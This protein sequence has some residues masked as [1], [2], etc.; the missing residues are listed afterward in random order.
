MQSRVCC[1]HCSG[2]PR[3]M[4][5]ARCAGHN[6]HS[7]SWSTRSFSDGSVLLNKCSIMCTALPAPAS[8]MVSPTV[9]RT[10][11]GHA[12]HHTMQARTSLRGPFDVPH[13]ATR[14]CA[15]QAQASV[16]GGVRTTDFLLS[17]PAGRGVTVRAAVEV[18]GPHHF[19]LSSATGKLE[20][21]NGSTA[22][23]D[24]ALRR[25]G[26]SVVTVPLAGRRAVRPGDDDFDTALA[27]R[28]WAVGVPLLGG[29]AAPARAPGATAQQ[30]ATAQYAT[31]HTGPS[32][33]AEAD[34]FASEAPLRRCAV[35]LAWQAAHRRQAAL[36][37]RWRRMQSGS[38][39][40]ST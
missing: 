15:L 22:L 11:H 38:V 24:A 13:A 30:G 36:A 9:L 35:V 5:R 25:D 31:A 28:L 21:I 37:E 32:A 17:W 7:S 16:C 1:E 18:D 23:R 27:E 40:H 26:M 6:V 10:G 34:A 12:A 2:S 4:S 33:G 39:A 14:P 20:H 19:L 29:S 8:R 3:G